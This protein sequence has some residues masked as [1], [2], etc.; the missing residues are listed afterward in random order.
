MNANQEGSGK[1]YGGG[2]VEQAL[3]CQQERWWEVYLYKWKGWHM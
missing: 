3:K 1:V 2:G